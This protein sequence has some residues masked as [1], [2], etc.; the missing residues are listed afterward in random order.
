MNLAAGGNFRNAFQ[1]RTVVPFPSKWN[2]SLFFST[3]FL[4]L[5]LALKPDVG[6]D[7]EA[8]HNFGLYRRDEC[9]KI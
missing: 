3:S 7:K 5:P 9:Y 8:F 1:D 2:F 6:L 4:I